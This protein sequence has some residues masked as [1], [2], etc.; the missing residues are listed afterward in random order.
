MR[1]KPANLKV[2]GPWFFQN[3]HG[4]K[5]LSGRVL[6]SQYVYILYNKEVLLTR[7][8][9]SPIG[10]AKMSSQCTDTCLCLACDC[11]CCTMRQTSSKMRSVCK[12][13]KCEW[14]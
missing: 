8:S 6:L 3:E 5:A 7:T 9:F 12:H 1:Y 4:Q 14:L 10:H 13:L 2:T 11:L